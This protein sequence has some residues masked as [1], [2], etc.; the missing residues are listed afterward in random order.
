MQYPSR[1]DFF[2]VIAYK[3]GIDDERQRSRAPSTDH[4]T[5]QHPATNIRHNR[6]GNEPCRGRNERRCFGSPRDL[7]TK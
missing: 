7:L 1:I 6:G 3:L 2:A 5:I 4:A